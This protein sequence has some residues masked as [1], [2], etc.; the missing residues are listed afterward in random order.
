MANDGHER[1]PAERPHPARDRQ[2]DEAEVAGPRPQR[3][4]GRDSAGA[5]DPRPPDAHRRRQPPPRPGAE[6]LSPFGVAVARD[7]HAPTPEPLSV[8][9]RHA[10]LRSVGGT[11]GG[12]RPTVLQTIPTERRWRRCTRRPEGLAGG[13]PAAGWRTRRVCEW[14]GVEADSLGRVVALD[15]TNNGLSGELPARLGHLAALTELRIRDNALS[16]RLPTSLT[17]LSL[18]ELRYSG[19]GLCAPADAS[20]S[21]WLSTIAAHVGSGLECAPTS[22]RDVLETLYRATG[23]PNWRNR[24]NWADRRSARSVARSRCRRRG[25][26]HRAAAGGQQS[27]RGHSSGAGVGSPVWRTSNSSATR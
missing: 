23:G 10:C 17:A 7:E 13:T 6:Q 22:D 15:L 8:P 27:R 18:R 5:R 12:P 9:A 4:H 24:T 19:T 3:P 20:F 21:A 11:V 16:G 14:F 25:P 1:K 26:R 2:I